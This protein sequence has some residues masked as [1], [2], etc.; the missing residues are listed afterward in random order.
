M[1]SRTGRKIGFLFTVAL[2]IVLMASIYVLPDGRLI[3]LWLMLA[4]VGFMAAVIKLIGKRGFPALFLFCF[5]L[6]PKKT[7]DSAWWGGFLA[8]TF[9]GQRGLVF[10]FFDY[11]LLP[12][13]AVAGLLLY[14]K[15]S[16]QRPLRS[17]AKPVLLFL[18]FAVTGTLT[19]AAFSYL[20]VR[21]FTFT[22]LPLIV[23]GTVGAMACYVV[24]KLPTSQIPSLFTMAVGYSRWAIMLLAFE[25]TLLKLHV[26][27]TILI[28]Q[29]YDLRGGFRSL[30]LGYTVYVA[31]FCMLGFFF[32][33]GNY[34]LKRRLTDA[35]LAA[36]AMIILLTTY[37][38][39]ALLATLIFLAVAVTLNAQR[40]RHTIRLSFAAL[41]FVVFSSAL[42]K[43]PLGNVVNEWSTV[44]GVEFLSTES[45]VDRFALQLRAVDVFLYQPVTGFGVFS[46][47]KVG[48]TEIP[49][50]FGESFGGRLSQGYH[51]RK[52]ATDE[53][54]TN[55][56]NIFF[57]M[58]ADT[59]L[60]VIPFLFFSALLPLRK[61]IR[62]RRSRLTRTPQLAISLATLVAL[63][64]YYMLQAI[65]LYLFVFVL[66]YVMSIP[67][68]PPQQEAPTLS[69][70]LPT[71]DEALPIATLTPTF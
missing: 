33:M 38:R 36:A 63:I 28:L 18:A 55:P 40:V 13:L 26:T 48:S 46:F 53:L 10:S 14:R 51:A 35:L 62:R 50:F 34:L 22:Y 66:V 3:R 27:P 31:F 12:S 39:A 47:Q 6:F 25:L 56:H 9:G 70:S 16:V 7:I 24:L 65:P 61:I 71:R 1:I 15:A 64:G 59:G 45:I 5:F 19:Y 49:P 32:V 44:K 4:W 21:G 20:S 43:N 23:L 30:W 57:Q 60:G 8:T 29:S 67:A 58:L 17:F 41:L 11:V 54:T 37:E 68:A 52:A 69:R 2:A 42:G